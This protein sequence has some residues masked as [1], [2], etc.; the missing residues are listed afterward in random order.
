MRFAAVPNNQNHAKSKP[1][2]PAGTLKAKQESAITSG[3]WLF[4]S[5]NI[6]QGLRQYL[7][8]LD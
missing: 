1:N 4:C 6:L 5:F 2:R 3:P 7:G 8:Y